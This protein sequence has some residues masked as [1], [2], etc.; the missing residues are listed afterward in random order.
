MLRRF[1]NFNLPSL[2]AY[3]RSHFPDIPESWHYADHYLNI[4]GSA[5]GGRNTR[6]AMVDTDN[7]RR[8]LA[9]KALVRWRHGLSAIEPRYHTEM[10]CSNKPSPDSSAS[11]TDRNMYLPVTNF[12]LDCELPVPFDLRFSQAEMQRDFVEQSVE[13]SVQSDAVRPLQSGLKKNLGKSYNYCEIDYTVVL[14]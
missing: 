12:L 6:D 7:A 10:S 9:K 2:S 4:R 5:E 3:L 11:S 8:S 13:E 1:E 14:Y